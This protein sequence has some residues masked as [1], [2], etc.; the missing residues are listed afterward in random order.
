M[1]SP[2]DANLLL[3]DTTA[4]E[5]LHG[6]LGG[7]GVVVLDETVVVTLR[8]ELKGDEASEK[9]LCDSIEEERKDVEVGKKKVVEVV[10][11][12]AVVAVVTMKGIYNVV[13]L[14][15]PCRA[16]TCAP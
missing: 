6:A 7:T 12:V 15:A 1:V 2:V 14:N 5:S 16:K 8:L 11:V 10:E 4:V 13:R 3:V 9:V